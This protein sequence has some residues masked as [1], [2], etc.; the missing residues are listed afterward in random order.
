VLRLLLPVFFC[1]IWWRGRAEP[2]WRLNWRQRL[3]RMP[4][5]RD[6]P[7]WVHAA[8]VGEANSAAS[9]FTQLQRDHPELPLHLTAFTPTGA[10]RLAE[11]VPAAQVTLLPL[12]LPWVLRRYINALNPRAFVVL[13]T[14]CWPNLLRLCAQRE[15]PV[16]WLSGRLSAKS[17]RR[18]PQVF[19]AR[20]LADALAT[21]KAFGVQTDAD[22]QG[23]E[24]L[25]APAERV[26]VAGSLML[27]L[28]LPADLQERAADWRRPLGARPIWIAASTHAGEEAAVLSVHAQLRQIYPK[29]LLLLAPRHPRR[30]EEVQALIAA[31]GLSFVRRSG[32]EELQ[33]AAVLLI[34]TLGEILFF[35]AAAD[36]AFVGGSLVP[37]G[38]HNLLEPAALAL[39]IFCGPHLQSCRDIADGLAA[40]GALI[41]VSSTQQLQENLQRC[42]D[43]P[44][45]AQN[46]GRTGAAYAAANRGSV[47]RSLALLQPY[48]GA[49]ASRQ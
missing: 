37:V 32:G 19:G 21:V 8:S 30:A 38:G 11:L 35:Y 18:Y 9:F 41:C 3:G 2:A 39:P 24:A 17:V 31:Q 15:I 6:H 10:A 27:D 23:F 16:L 42:F 1:F 4:A 7:L 26:H 34:D 46:M 5:R 29:A 48:L 47:A 14:E 13:E 25:G 44:A 20:L 45:R 40:Q 33:D 36:A 28:Q 49:P 22:R 43:D 12:D